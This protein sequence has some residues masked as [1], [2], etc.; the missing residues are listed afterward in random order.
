[1]AAQIKFRDVTLGYDRHPAVHH[2]SSEVAQGALLAVVGPNG[3]GKSTL[4]RGLAGILQPLAGSTTATTFPIWSAP[5][6]LHLDPAGHAVLQEKG[7]TFSGATRMR[8]NVDQ[9]GYHELSVRIDSV[10]RVPVTLAPLSRCVHRISPRPESR[11]D[12]PQDR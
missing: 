9:A 4:F 2:L 8:V 5:V 12:G 3:A 7:G 11:Q 1:M 6:C 10:G